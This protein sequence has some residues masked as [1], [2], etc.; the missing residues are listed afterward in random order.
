MLRQLDEYHKYSF[1]GE[2]EIARSFEKVVPGWFQFYRRFRP[3]LAYLNSCPGNSTLSADLVIGMISNVNLDFLLLCYKFQ[4]IRA[5]HAHL[6]AMRRRTG[7]KVLFSVCRSGQRHGKQSAEKDRAHGF[8]HVLKPPCKNNRTACLK[9]IQMP[10]ALPD[11]LRL[12][13]NAHDR[14]VVGGFLL[15]G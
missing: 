2:G 15:R 11:A 1:R 14:R 13:L 6:A 12:L 7:I 10:A 9:P 5:R 8:N 4:M 3:V